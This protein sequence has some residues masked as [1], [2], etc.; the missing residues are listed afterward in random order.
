MNSDL[1]FEKSVARP[2]NGRILRRL[3]AINFA[4]LLLWI[5]LVGYRYY[6]RMELI[7]RIE[8]ES[9]PAATLSLI[10]LRAVR[11][12]KSGPTCLRDWIGDDNMR[13]F[14]Q[15]DRVTLRCGNVD[16]PELT[17]FPEIRELAVCSTLFDHH[18]WRSLC[19]LEQ[20]E[21]LAIYNCSIHDDDLEALAAMKSLK[22]LHVE[23]EPNI[24]DRGLAFLAK[25]PSLEVLEVDTYPDLSGK[26]SEKGLAHLTQLRKLSVGGLTEDKLNSLRRRLPDCEINTNLFSGTMLGGFSPWR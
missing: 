4:M 10:R 5:G 1:P 6:R 17:E 15:V 19:N 13:G 16:L 25:L 8:R 2:T 18:S 14:E 22:W 12:Q 26:I 20:L 21:R 24:T 9:L 7:R 11:T 23:T 3:V